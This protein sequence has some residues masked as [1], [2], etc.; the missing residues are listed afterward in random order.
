[1]FNESDNVMKIYV[2]GPGSAEPATD[3]KGRRVSIGG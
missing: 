2:E 3:S 1:M